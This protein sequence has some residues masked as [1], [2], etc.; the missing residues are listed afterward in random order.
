MG[1]K[2]EKQSG[3]HFLSGP[4]EKVPREGGEGESGAVGSIYIGSSR[5][6]FR[7]DVYVGPTTTTEM[8]CVLPSR[9]HMWRDGV[10]PTAATQALVNPPSHG[11]KPVVPN[12]AARR[13]ALIATIGLARRKGAM[14]CNIFSR[15]VFLKF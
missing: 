2:E 8:G 5:Q 7:R 6:T 13:S 11:V 10:G 3:Q 12:M 15:M 9:R 14:G 1:K 4:G